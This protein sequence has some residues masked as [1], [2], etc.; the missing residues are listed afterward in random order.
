MRDRGAGGRKGLTDMPEPM[1]GTGTGSNPGWLLRA[2]MASC[3]AT[4]IAMRAASWDCASALEVKVESE[5]DARGLVGIPEIPT[6]LGNMRMSVTIGA[7][8]VDETRLRE[9]AAWGEE[10]SP[11]GCTIRDG[12]AVRSKSSR[13]ERHPTNSHAPSTRI[14]NMNV[15]STSRLLCHQAAS[16]SHLG[17]RRLCR[18]RHNPSDR[19]RTL[20]EA[21]DL[22]AGER[23]I[24]VAAGNGNA[25]LA[26]ARRW[27]EVTSTDYVPHCWT[28]PRS[29]RPRNGFRSRVRRPTP[30]RCLSLTMGLTLFCRRLA[31]CSRLIRKRRRAS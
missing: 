7:E 20:C 15:I 3:A 17:S 22:R 6:A 18:G 16:A 19:W 31:S 8:G 13:S 27:A 11:V 21:V 12:S 28:V 9:L 5:L 30:K 24:D 23:V 1:G 10:Y 14:S 25:T 26:A 4:S 2:G 29:A